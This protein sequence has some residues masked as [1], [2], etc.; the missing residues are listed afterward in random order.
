MAVP[1]NRT[2]HYFDAAISTALCYFFSPTIIHHFYGFDTE[3]AF[4]YPDFAA[5]L[6]I[7][8][9]LAKMLVYFICR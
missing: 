4:P 8:F 3:A 5:G 9:G 2:L 7:S 1:C 6:A